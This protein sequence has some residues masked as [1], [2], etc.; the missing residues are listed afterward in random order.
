MATIRIK[1]FSSFCDSNQAKTT[2]EKICESQSIDFY[3]ADKDM[4]I[5]DADS[6][7]FSHVII[8]N[9]AMPEIPATIPKSN[10][11]GL[12]FEPPF[13]LGMTIAF[14]EYASKY[15]G[16]YFIGNSAGLPPPFVE[17][18]SY[19]WHMPI[20]HHIPTKTNWCSLI[21]SDKKHAPGHKYRHEM[22]KSILRTKLPI[23][24]YGRGCKYF[25]YLGDSRIKG[26]FQETEPY[27]SYMFHVCIEN[28]QT[29]EYFSEKIINPLL[30][31]TIPIYWGCHHIESHFPDMVIRLTGN[32]MNDIGLLRSCFNNPFAFRKQIPVEYVKEK[33]NFLRNIRPLLQ[34]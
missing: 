26:E 13:Y 31:S 24:I 29:N 14:V 20:L 19:M 12:A 15:I 3:G 34:S 9:T 28:F 4:Y 7:E 33:I 27:E 32:S 6:T 2:F 25:A 21:F 5:V 18:Y 16:R 1:I 22:V 8:I 30:S 17:H 11:I 10:V 23:D